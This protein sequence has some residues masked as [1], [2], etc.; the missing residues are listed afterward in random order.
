M[1][2]SAETKVCPHC[3]ETIKAAAKVC[4]HCR[5]AQKRWSLY[6]P[7]MLATVWMILCFVAM[8][9]LGIFFEKAFGPKEQFA[10]YRDDIAVVGSQFSHRISDSNL[11]NTVVGM[12]T[13][14]SDVEWKDVGVEARF[15]DKSGKEIDAITVKAEDYRA[16]AILPHGEVAFKIESVAARPEADYDSYKAVVRWAK[17]ASEWP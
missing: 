11:V 16:V 14:R 15:F 17:N 5:Y 7:Q 2:E 9:G 12:L 10:T 8:A 4:P 6:N 1:N 13:N 3:A